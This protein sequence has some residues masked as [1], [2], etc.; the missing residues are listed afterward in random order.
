MS[1][2]SLTAVPA[3]EPAKTPEQLLQPQLEAKAA[4]L[5]VKH[6]VPVHPILFFDVKSDPTKQDPVIGYIKEPA[7]EVKVR[8]LDKGEQQGIFAAA[9]EMLEFCLDKEASDARI[10][11][12]KPCNDK[13]VLG[14]CLQAQQ[15]IE[16]AISFFKKK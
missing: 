6:G 16:I 15:I 5:S 8:V 13:Y 11:D 3:V 10:S 9:L 4:E 1:K 7:L 14:A 2:K 12:R